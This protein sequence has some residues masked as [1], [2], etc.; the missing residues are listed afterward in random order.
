[1]ANKPIGYH[2][3]LIK[4]DNTYMRDLAGFYTPTISPNF[5]SPEKILFNHELAAELGIEESQLS[6]AALSGQEPPEGAAMIAMAYAGHQFGGF[7]PSL[8]DG[9]AT[10]LG[11]VIDRN[12]A[13]KDIH[14][15]GSGRTE[16]SRGGDGK[17]ALGPVLREYLMGEAM[18]ALNIPTTRALG[19][20]TTGE[21][22]LRDSIKPGAVLTRIASSHLRVG[23]FEY[24][25]ARGEMDKVRQLAD[26]AIARHYPEASQTE[27]P[28]LDFLSAVINAQAYLVAKWMS[29]GFVHGVMNTDNVAISGETIDYGP[30]AFM[31]RYDPKTVFSSIDAHGR[32]AYEKQ[33][34]MAH[35]NLA[36]LAETMLP[37]LHPEE[38]VA[39]KM[40]NNVIASFQDRYTYYW[41]QN[42]FAKLGIYEPTPEDSTLL[43]DMYEII[44]GQ[45]VDFTLFFRRLADALEG[46]DHVLDLFDDDE[47]AA[48]WLERWIKRV[49]DA[50]IAADMDAVNPIYI[51]RNHLVNDALEAAEN[52]QDM[53]KFNQ[54][55][56]VLSDP[57]TE[58]EDL[59]EFENPAPI[60]AEPFRTFCGT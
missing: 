38:E 56:D 43:A 40:A 24:F 47:L 18:H 2:L 26:Y 13:R 22:I 9:R 37:I 55:L 19:A 45:N 14:L 42:M 5:P 20:V 34:I 31:D 32:Y 25:H 17:A 36:R 53:S 15:K 57:Y 8:G 33:P 23:S 48:L 52:N 54:L 10:L 1:M 16:Y 39:F 41:L 7:S 30:C 4:F 58:R 46:N 51:P 21:N 12:G 49:A 29:I 44:K 27:N 11:E 60:D 6:A 50:D 35:W 3:P 28:Y 59:S